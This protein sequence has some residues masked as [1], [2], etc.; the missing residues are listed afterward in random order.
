MGPKTRENDGQR[1]RPIPVNVKTDQTV[2][3][4]EIPIR[5]TSQNKIEDGLE[6]A[7][8]TE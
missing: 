7:G 8:T 4:H 1:K 5:D 6:Q 2:K 3:R